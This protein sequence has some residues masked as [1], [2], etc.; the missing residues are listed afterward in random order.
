VKKKIQPPKVAKRKP[1]K[2]QNKEAYKLT[3]K[4]ID[5]MMKKGEKNLRPAELKTLR[6][7][8][9]AAE[10]FE[11]KFQPLPVYGIAS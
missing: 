6:T 5:A 3:M 7:L 10:A 4:E 11:D 1:V 2:I 8:A 9:E